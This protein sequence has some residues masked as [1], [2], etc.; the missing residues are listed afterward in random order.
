MTRQS[1]HLICRGIRN[2]RFSL[3]N[4][5]VVDK[6]FILSLQAS[7]KLTTSL[8]PEIDN[9][10]STTEDVILCIHG[11][12]ASSYFSFIR[13]CRWFFFLLTVCEQQ[14]NNFTV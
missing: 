6:I 1:V 12:V 7:T 5:F 14:F 8:V 2:Y 13:S 10:V 3:C 4:F 9:K 11:T